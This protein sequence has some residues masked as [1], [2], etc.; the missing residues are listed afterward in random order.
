M[1]H[2][3][4]IYHNNFYNTIIIFFAG[5]TLDCPTCQD[6]DCE[7]DISLIKCGRTSSPLINFN[8]NIE[9]NEIDP[10]YGCLDL[11]YYD[12]GE[13]YTVSKTIPYQLNFYKLSA[14]FV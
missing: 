10:D 8:I 9:S 5:F 3:H 13:S 12:D 1:Y 6:S 7:L 14:I 11:E 4:T 2:H